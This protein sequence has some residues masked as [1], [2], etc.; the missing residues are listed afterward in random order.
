MSLVGSL[1][2]LG[3]GDILQI[4]SLSR[5]SG[6]LNLNWGELR[7]Q[8]LFQDGQVITATSTEMSQHLGSLLLEH[9]I[10]TQEVLAQA[11]TEA[12]SSRNKLSEILVEKFSVDRKTV[13]DVVK[14]QVEESIFSFFTW[15]EGNFNF[16]L[17]D[18]ND[19]ISA[20]NDD[21]Q[22][23]TLEIGLSPQYLAMEGTR[24]QD[25]QRR[26]TPVG[27]PI[28]LPTSVPMSSEPEPEE[29][30]EPDAEPEQPSAPTESFD[31][32]QDFSSV[33]DAVKFYEQQAAADL[34]QEPAEPL[35]DDSEDIA[36]SEPS[37]PEPPASEPESS[38]EPPVPDLL[39]VP[40][41]L[42]VDDDPLMLE[43]LAH[44]L[45]QNLLMETSGDIDQALSRYQELLEQRKAP[46]V[47][48]DL[49]MPDMD[50]STTLGG[51][52]LCEK[53]LEL[54]PG[55]RFILMTDYENQDAQE[56]AKALGIKYFLFKPKSSQLET[57]Y[58]SP[59]LLNFIQ[60]FTN[61]LETLS[62]PTAGAPKPLQRDENG[63]V[64]LGD[65]LRKE[66]ADGE[67]FI[68]NTAA[69]ASQVV[70]SRGLGMLKAMINE[71]NDPGSEGQIT[72]MV[73]RFAAEIMNRA[74]I[75]LVARN[76]I[77]GLGQF[78]IDLNG[79]DPE[80]QVRRIRI[81]LNEP[82]IFRETV[83]KRMAL[84]KKLRSTKWNQY[85]VEILGGKAPDEVF[86]APIITGGKIAA[87]IY[88]DNVP[89]EKEIGD[90][91]SLEIFLAQAGLAMEKA[92]LERRL[93]EKASKL[94]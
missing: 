58:S 22:E 87:L 37:A 38:S 33:A 2:D 68:S 50:Y 91:E 76:Q 9:K 4:V 46:V 93:Q 94:K 47:L 8:I 40:D 34:Q 18:I 80:Q 61:A 75:F 51:L 88:G 83:I 32:E 57:D 20:L 65:E 5:K 19:E 10:V 72:L 1:E 13:E 78:G 11:R 90:T 3:L 45:G 14:D 7:G 70:S 81:P 39:T 24:L 12:E 74:V 84:K 89:E 64:N 42:A 86:V 63:L 71:L 26:D 60:V 55:A 67:E 92:L 59:E 15:P 62:A 66:F 48:A 79:V 6:V 53:V 35:T 28:K 85:L 16:E 44:H 69:D 31:D 25:E 73:L 52:E 54:D 49:L 36:G 30:P 21:E 23:F 27:K 17:M 82:S 41:L 29:F 43:S 77:A 56:R